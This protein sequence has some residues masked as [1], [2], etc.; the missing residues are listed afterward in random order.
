MMNAL[1]K[2]RRV[3]PVFRELHGDKTRLFDILA[4]YLTGIVTAILLLY[5]PG[6]FTSEST[7]SSW[8]TILT[9]FLAVDIGG[10]VVANLSS[11]TNRYYQDHQ[12]MRLPFLG[13]HLLHPLLLFAVFPADW[14]LW[15]YMA[16]TAVPGALIVNAVKHGETQQHLA[17][18]IVVMASAGVFLVPTE[19][20]VLRL[21]PFLFLIKL[22]LGFAVRRTGEPGEATG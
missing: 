16:T 6:V 11:S 19:V 21:F 18:S 12:G 3:A 5:A 7:W 15:A 4:V 2:Y 8:K 22:V 17:A 13:I 14:P 10:G 1:F 9:V 20:A